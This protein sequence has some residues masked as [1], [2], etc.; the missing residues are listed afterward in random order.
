MADTKKETQAF[1]DAL[2]ALPREKDGNFVK[3]AEA[4]KALLFS[5]KDKLERDPDDV[6]LKNN[7]NEWVRTFK[8]EVEKRS[9][10]SP[11]DRGALTENLGFVGPKQFPFELPASLANFSAQELLARDLNNNEC[12]IVCAYALHMLGSEEAW[13]KVLDAMSK[14]LVQASRTE[15]QEERNEEENRDEENEEKNKDEEKEENNKDEEKEEKTKDEEKEDKNKE[16][17]QE[18]KE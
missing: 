2:R 10:L 4:F 5:K 12:N 14:R 17:E 9:F 15:P 11:E 13:L 1:S 8:Q 6:R 7:I 18:E 16:E 3:K